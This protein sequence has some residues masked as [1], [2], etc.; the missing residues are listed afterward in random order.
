M[1]LSTHYYVMSLGEQT[2][3]LYEA[4]RD[5]LI[6]IQNSLFP[7]MSSHGV[8]EKVDSALTESELK[9]FIIKVDQHFDHYFRQDPLHF[10]A[11]GNKYDL[12]IFD[13]V[14][15]HREV[16]LGRAEGDFTASSPD[17]VGKIVWPIVKEA[18]S[19]AS[20]NAMQDLE[21]V[22]NSQNIAHGIEEVGHLAGTGMGNT[23][24]VEEDYHIKGAIRSAD[25]SLIPPEELSFLEVIDD[26]VDAVIEKVLGNGGNVVFVQSGS[27]TKLRRIALISTG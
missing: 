4:F 5:N 22:K 10:V 23:L 11:I 19:G 21:K 15:S 8:N 26:A 25:Q 13:E 14:T 17:D 24:F 9:E 16:L 18:M 7:V 3:R 27:L 12:S 1:R 6:D 20:E 2:T